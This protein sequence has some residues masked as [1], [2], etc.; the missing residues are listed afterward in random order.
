[1]LSSSERRIPERGMMSYAGC[2]R[3]KRHMN[4]ELK[5]VFVALHTLQKIDGYICSSG[6]AIE[7]SDNKRLGMDVRE[8]RCNLRGQP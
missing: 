5:I 3:S 6:E 7:L 1:M 2:S 4:V 8:E